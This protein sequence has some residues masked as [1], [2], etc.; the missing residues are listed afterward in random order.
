MN[1]NNID[2]ALSALGDALKSQEPDLNPLQLIAKFPDRSLNGNLINGGKILNFESSGIKDSASSTKITIDN[3]KVTID[4]L[5][6]NIIPNSLGILGDLNVDGTLR[7]DTIEVENLKTNLDID[8]SKAIKY[9]GDINGKGFLWAGKDY[10]KQFVYQTDKIFSSETINIAKDKN[11][12][13][14]DVKVIDAESLGASVV[15]SNLRQVGTLQGLIVDGT[16]N[17]NNYMIFD[18]GSDRLGI[19]TDEPNAALSVAEDGVEVIVGTADSTRGMIGTFASHQLDIVTDNFSRINIGTNGDILL[20]NRKSAPIQ[21]S[22]HGKL[23]VRVNMPDPEVDLHVNGAVKFNNKLQTHGTSYPT[24][25]DFNKGDIVWNSE[26]Q[27]KSYVGWVCTKA[28]N[29]GVWEPFGKIG[30]E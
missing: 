11:I 29:P 27:L 2:Q 30:N 23:A 20:G 3:D 15:R 14:N 7:V 6:T 22:V 26:P 8:Q 9:S 19:G 16:M 18:A 10:T 28:G 12:S 4:T 24:V 13:I 21:A 1:K 17:I 5:A 25:G